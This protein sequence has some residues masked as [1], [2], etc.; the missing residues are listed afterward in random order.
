VTKLFEQFDEGNKGYLTA[1]EFTKLMRQ[2]S[3]SQENWKLM[4]IYE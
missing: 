1:E 4:A 3:A 2:E